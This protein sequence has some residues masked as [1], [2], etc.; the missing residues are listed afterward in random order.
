MGC[1]R[2]RQVLLE[3]KARYPEIG[4]PGFRLILVAVQFGKFSVFS[5]EVKDHLL[6]GGEVPEDFGRVDLLSGFLD[7]SSRCGCLGVCD[8]VGDFQDLLHSEGIGEDLAGVYVVTSQDDL[9][10]A[11]TGDG[12]GPGRLISVFQL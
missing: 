11:V 10:I 1:F 2:R 9:I 8:G 4:M 7:R 5:F 12:T 6:F 3:K